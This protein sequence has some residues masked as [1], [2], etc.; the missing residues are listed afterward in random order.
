ML[1]TLLASGVFAVSATAG[2]EPSL[3]VLCW[4]IWRGGIEKEESGK[5]HQVAAL[6]KN[7]APDLVAMQET[8]GSGPWLSEQLGYKLRLRG[9]HLSI[10][11]QHP[12][13]HDL[14]VGGEWNCIGAVVETPDFGQVAIFSV[15]LPFNG[16]VWAPGSR[17]QV[18]QSQMLEVCEPSRAVLTEL[19]PKIE[20]KLEEEDLTTIPVIIA[21][22]FN[23]MSHLDYT[24]EN[25]TQYGGQVIAWPTSKLM[26]ESGFADTYR[27]MHPM[28]NRQKDRTWSP[29]FTN[30]EADRID[31]IYARGADL[32]PASSRI[33]DKWTPF[34]PSDHAVVITTFG[35][36]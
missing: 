10:F 6:I 2:E 33:I 7:E 13:R 4:N 36:P 34:F 17:D 23:S 27:I 29:E 15:W 35:K 21:G 30:Q 8:Y 24:E 3:K 20:Q 12:V 28:V 31:F 25:A 32:K 19:L 18:T 16:D 22:D 11:S 14:S 9:P 5:P 1:A 26:V